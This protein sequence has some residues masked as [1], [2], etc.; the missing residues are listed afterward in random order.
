MP[1]PRLTSAAL[2]VA[3]ALPAAASELSN[4]FEP[5]LRDLAE[6]RIAPLLSERALVAAIRA[7]NARTAGLSEEEILALD[8]EWRGAVGGDDPLI[9]GVTGSAEAAFLRE[10]REGS[11]GLYTEIFL[12]D[13]VGLNVAA[14][15]VTSDYWQGDE[16]KWQETYAVGPGRVHVS[17]IDFDESTQSYQSQVSLTIVD[18]ETGEPIGAATF[19]VNIAYLE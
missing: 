1:F 19:G 7:Q 12:M 14:S 3:V 15:D 8:T 10:V 13:A 2:V 9:D 17:E 6:T 5:A 11:Q 4:E 16:A 18:P